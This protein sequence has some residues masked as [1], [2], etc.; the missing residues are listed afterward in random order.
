MWR[1]CY[2]NTKLAPHPQI[3]THI[4]LSWYILVYLF[5]FI[6]FS[7]LFFFITCFIYLFIY[8][9]HYHYHYYMMMMMMMWRLLLP[10]KNTARLKK[11]KRKQKCFN[12]KTKENQFFN[13]NV[14]S[15]LFCEHICCC[16]WYFIFSLLC[17]CTPADVCFIYLFIYFSLFCWF[18]WISK[19][20]FKTSATESSRIRIKK[21]EQKTHRSAQKI[22][23][24]NII[25]PTT[26][27]KS[28][29][30]SSFYN[31]EITSFFS[32]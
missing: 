19:N 14:L 5:L 9:H 11:K 25:Q 18:V 6:D 4:I 12:N 31:Q 1:V 32:I 16:Y 28:S 26:N 20:N 30:L 23:K 15:F 8:I 3:T 27:H 17:V 2:T 24:Q 29:S 7:F 13:I 10:I 22:N 21:I